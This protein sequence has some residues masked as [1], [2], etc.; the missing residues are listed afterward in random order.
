MAL[1]S[2]RKIARNRASLLVFASL[3]FLS[4]Y[5]FFIQRPS[6]SSVNVPSHQSHRNQLAEAL[7]AVRKSG[8]GHRKPYLSD[9]PQI[10]LT[11]EQE[12][13]A[14]SSFLSA[15]SSNSIP[16]P[17]DPQ[18]PI[19]PELVLEFDTRSSRA[20][21]EVEAMV[22]EVWTRNPVFLY[23]KLYSPVSRE[24]KA[25]LM[26]MNL[27]PAP[28]II[29]V[30]IRADADALKPLLMR[31]TSSSD[32]PILLVGGQSVGSVTDI[33]EMTEN[34]ELQR[35]IYE[36]GAVTIEKKKKNKK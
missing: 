3:F 24:I 20:S 10:E 29:D 33:R 36:A 14:V 8:S 7:Q 35:R 21:E 23:S 2:P 32:L 13:A 11:A 30:D 6:L 31:V 1:K 28:T 16:L 18:R 17:V 4:C 19:D 15:L 25:T 9:R 5:I 27:H 22:Q 34:G 12:L 26:S